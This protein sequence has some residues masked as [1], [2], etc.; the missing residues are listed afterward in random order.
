MSADSLSDGPQRVWL[1]V[2]DD[3]SWVLCTCTF[4]AA[5]GK[6]TLTRLHGKFPDTNS[7]QITMSNEEVAKL[8]PAH[9]DLDTPA[10]DLV[11]LEDVHECTMLHNL[12]LRYAK[13]KIYTAIGPVLLAINPYKKVGD[14][15]GYE[16]SLNMEVEAPPHCNKTSRAAYAGLL[17]GTPQ[18]ILISGESGAGKTETNKI[19]MS[20]LA[21]ISNSTGVKTTEQSLQAGIL[22]EAF[23][24]ARTVYNNNSSRFGKWCAVFF[25]TQGKMSAT[26]VKSYLLEK[27]RVVGPSQGERNYHIFY[28]MVAGASADERKAYALQSAHGGYRYLQGEASADGIDD[29]AEWASTKSMLGVLGF[30]A[31]H[32]GQL[33]ALYAAVLALGNVTFEAAAKADTFQVKD[34]KLLETAATLL[35]VPPTTLAAKLT[36]RVMTTVSSS[37]TVPLTEEQCADTR[38]A[39]A[40]AVYAGLFDWLIARMNALGAD[41]IAAG[42]DR[43]IGL[44]D[45]FGFENFG[46]NGFEQLCINFTNEKLQQHFMDALIKREQAEYAREGIKVDHIAFPDNTPQIALIDHKK[47]G[48][49][50][51]L[52]EECNVPKGSDAAYVSKMHA[53]FASSEFYSP[54]KFGSA[55]LGKDL[56]EKLAKLQFI[57]THYA[58]PVQYT[59]HEWLEKNRGTLH[60]GL[61][62]LMASSDAPGMQVIFQKTPEELKTGKKQTVGAGFRASLR[63]LSATM[64]MTTQHF[65][66]CVKPNGDKKPDAFNGQFVQRQLKYTGVHSVVD[67]HRAGYPIKF[68]MGDFVKRYRCIAFDQPRLISDKLPDQERSVNLLNLAH[69]LATADPKS[70]EKGER[71]WLESMRVQLG[72]TRVFMRGDIVKHI[73]KPRHAAQTRAAI[74][75]QRYARTRLIRR[76]AKLTTQHKALAGAVKTALAGEEGKTTGRA[77]AMVQRRLDDAGALLDRLLAVWQKAAVSPEAD[78]TGGLLELK[79]E[80]S[81]LEVQVR[82]TQTGLLKEKEAVAQLER[83]VADTT[84]S[85][86]QA[87]VALKTAVAVANEASRGLTEELEA[88]IAS[89][90]AELASRFAEMLKQWEAE[91]QKIAIEREA[92]RKKK[93]AAVE[94]ELLDVLRRPADVEVRTLTLRNGKDGKGFNLSGYTL[95]QMVQGGAPGV[96]F[97]GANSVSIVVVG[98]AAA[99]DNLLRVGDTVLCVDD[100]PLLGEKV[101][102]RMDAKPSASYKLTIARRKVDVGASGEEALPMGDKEGWMYLTKAEDGGNK[103]LH[104]PKKCWAVLLGEVLVFH[105]EVVRGQERVAHPQPLKG[106]IVKVPMS[107]KLTMNKA[108]TMNFDT[109]SL[110][111]NKSDAKALGRKEVERLKD[112]KI[113]AQQRQKETTAIEQTA[114]VAELLQRKLAPFRLTWPDGELA[115]DLV[116]A[117]D[118]AEARTDWQKALQGALDRINANAPTSGWLEKQKGRGGGMAAMTKVLGWDKRWFVLTQPEVAGELPR[119]EYFERPGAPVAKGSIALNKQATLLVSEQ[120]KSDN[121]F[122][123]CVTSQGPDDKKPITTTLAATKGGELDK[124]TMA[125]RRAIRGEE[126]DKKAKAERL[127]LEKAEA[128]LFRKTPEQLQQLLDYMGKGAMHANRSVKDKGL[129]VQCVVSAREASKAGSSAAKSGGADGGAKQLRDQMSHEEAQLG[130]RTVEELKALLEFMEVDF[131]DRLEDKHKLISL[132]VR[133]KNLQAVAQSVAPGLLKWKAKSASRVDLTAKK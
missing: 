115:Y 46:V 40:K 14:V 8:R 9:G 119:F 69:K 35:Q 56:G 5:S 60:P 84:G 71:P 62:E 101:S 89:V 34:S 131:D 53:A 92:E 85:S 82:S 90:E 55:A 64:L 125:I 114:A 120:L 96:T 123:F 10:S 88:A 38:D 4:A 15:L 98:G 45:I 81:E 91:A 17:E 80:L 124:W 21:Q 30:S 130:K 75:V 73:E 3:D 107:K 118:D 39:L 113:V 43:Y 93:Q 76:V 6:T 12:R 132:V 31:D 129:L 29:V 7:S 83:T 102:A 51:M 95:E 37:Y 54:P 97:D 11:W 52:D 110:K 22:L 108:G 87:F 59:A 121:P 66:R 79:A 23:G 70:G 28:Q 116:C 32:S 103:P 58:G 109:Q 133:Q 68:T 26:Q 49:F 77:A 78:P 65:I 20:C 44:L 111:L 128:D 63:A 104:A 126:E 127:R 122:G 117:V 86:K 24:N 94:A 105:E 33:F 57:V 99:R 18:S 112:S 42:D 67:I 16:H 100:A 72:K 2:K 27:S 50:A 106:S 13:D 19:C 25:D 61:S 48:V 47:Q 36:T 41:K 1:P 74:C